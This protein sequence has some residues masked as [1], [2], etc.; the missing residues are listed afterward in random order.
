M[1]EIL[2]IEG[3]PTFDESIIQYEYHTH[4]PYASTRYGNN[5]EIRIPVQQ[6]DVFTL[7]AESF[8]HIE[9]KLTKDDSATT[10]NVNLVN[11][12]MAFLFEEIRYEV[13]GVEVD[14]TK[15]VGITSTVKTLLSANE[16]DTKRLINAGWV[17]PAN[18][19]LAVDASTGDFNFCVPLKMLLGFAEDY[20]RII[21]NIKQELILLRTSTDV[22]AMVKT[23]AAGAANGKLELIKVHWKMPYVRVANAYRLPLLHHVERDRPLVMPFRSWELHE[24]P[25]LPTTDRQT[26][27]VKTSSELEKPRYVVLMFQTARKNDI[28]KN[29]SEF[30]HCNLTNVR[31]FLNDKYYP[32][33]NLNQDISKGR[34]ALFYDMYTRFQNSYYHRHDSGPLLSPD[35]F[36]TKTPL[37]VIDCSRQDE[38]LKSAA[39]DIRLE[40]ESSANFPE[41]TTA[42]ALIIHDTIVQYTPLSNTV[43]RVT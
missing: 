20:T 14:R 31:L 39:V 24:Y 15:N 23:N 38:T 41:K 11:N 3:G 25:V 40:F 17:A 42:Y 37:F 1:S 6:Q 16:R 2:A 4:A 33:D 29:A 27:T 43:H 7:P 21:M 9:G 34:F 10:L 18:D 36:K 26:W 13:G 22:N 30:D 12:A 5:D 32:Y 19:A 35:H 28:T 8:L